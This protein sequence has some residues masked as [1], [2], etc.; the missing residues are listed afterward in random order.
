MMKT[1]PVPATATATVSASDKKIASYYVIPVAPG[2]GS[3]QNLVYY[4]AFPGALKWNKVSSKKLNARG[5]GKN[6]SMIKLAQATAEQIA[7][8]TDLP[9]DIL[10][11][12]ANLY[13]GVAR[14]LEENDELPSVYSLTTDGYLIIP[15][16]ADT[17]RGLILLFT[18]SQGPG[19]AITGIIASTDP[20]IQNSVGT[21]E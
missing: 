1:E 19:S 3:T 9:R 17:K 5:Q 18:K 4:E 21:T 13:A 10:D 15:V 20:E 2:E 8:C 11:P 16:L 7:L 6:A 12:T 14:T